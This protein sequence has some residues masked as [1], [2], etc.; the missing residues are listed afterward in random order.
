MMAN[1]AYTSAA[2][3][4][5]CFTVDQEPNVNSDSYLSL[6][7]KRLMRTS[8]W[9][10]DETTVLST[11]EHPSSQTC[12][13]LIVFHVICVWRAA[14]ATGRCV[15]RCLKQASN[16]PPSPPKKRALITMI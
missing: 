16:P 1:Y 10:E 12:C 5:S 9:V 11:V 2:H 7:I 6:L 4:A 3:R 8:K 15:P 14:F 13:N